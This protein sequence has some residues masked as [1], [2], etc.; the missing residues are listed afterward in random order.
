[1]PPRDGAEHDGNE[2]RACQVEARHQTGKLRQRTNAEAADR[3]RHRSEC[4]DRRCFHDQVDDPEQDLRHLLDEVDDG[5]RCAASGAER[6]ADQHRDQQHLE[7]VASGER[8][9]H[10]RGNDVEQETGNALRSARRHVLRHRLRVERRGIDIH[11]A[12]R[13]HHV[14]DN[15]ADHQRE[16]RHDL[17]VDQ[18]EDAGL[19]HRPAARA[20]RDADD[21]RAEDDRRDNHAHELDERVAER[22]HRDA[23][24]W[25]QVP[26]ENTEGRGDQYLTVERLRIAGLRIGCH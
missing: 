2:R 17:E 25:P 23:G 24:R 14:D 12:T 6:E 20:A 19:A 16:R 1:M 15:Q 4:A 7:D 3:E 21:D 10:A 8:V 26:D 11:A 9:D 5:G 18:G 13:P 22:F